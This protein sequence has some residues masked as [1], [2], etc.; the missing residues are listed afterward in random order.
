[1]GLSDWANLASITTGIIAVFGACAY[2]RRMYVW[3]QKAC[4]L[5]DFLKA[6]R[7]KGPGHG[8]R[9]IVRIV[10]DVGLTEDEILKLSFA[11]K[12]IRRRV[13]VDKLTNLATELLFEYDPD[14]NNSK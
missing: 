2:F 1:M 6:E 10:Q 4:R 7:A 8:Q 11:S 5:E 13:T 3:R 9:S 12:N 14:Y